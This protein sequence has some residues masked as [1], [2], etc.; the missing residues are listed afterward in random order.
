[1]RLLRGIANMD[2]R[3]LDPGTHR[4]SYL[5][6][7]STSFTNPLQSLPPRLSY[8]ST[9]LNPHLH[10]PTSGSS[11]GLR[12]GPGVPYLSTVYGVPWSST[13]VGPPSTPKVNSTPSPS[14]NPSQSLLT[15]HSHA[16]QDALM[17]LQTQARFENV[18]RDLSSCAST[19]KYAIRMQDISCRVVNR[20]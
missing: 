18:N 8:T 20:I 14:V 16:V 11:T 6:N 9:P 13:G 17:A 7:P 10:N 19:S 12:P 4:L 15:V 5:S 1:M 2:G 3:G